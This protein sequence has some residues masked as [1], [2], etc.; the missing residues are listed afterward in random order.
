MAMP[1]IRRVFSDYADALRAYRCI[2]VQHLM[3]DTY[4]FL[5]ELLEHGVEIDHL[6]VKE[7]SCDEGYYDRLRGHVSLQRI[8]GDMSP[9]YMVALQESIEKSK[10]DGKRIAILDLGGEFAPIVAATDSHGVDIMSHY[11][12]AYRNIIFIFR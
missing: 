2:V 5:M 1:L 7:Y 11:C 9:R 6:F 10:R 8:G 3:S 4:C 12:C